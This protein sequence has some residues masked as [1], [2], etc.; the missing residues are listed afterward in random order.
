MFELS[1]AQLLSSLPPELG[2][3]LADFCQKL[4]VALRRALSSPVDQ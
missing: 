1:A 4:A 3:L 2:D